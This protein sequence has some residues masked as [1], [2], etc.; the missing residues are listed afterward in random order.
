MWMWTW[1]VDTHVNVNMES[2]QLTI[3]TVHIHIQDA[4]HIK[5]RLNQDFWRCV[6]AGARADNH[7]TTSKTST[8]SHTTTCIHARLV[9]PPPHPHSALPPLTGLLRRSA[10]WVVTHVTHICD[11]HTSVSNS[12]FTTLNFSNFQ[13]LCLQVSTFH[14]S[15]FQ[16]LCLQVS[17][18]QTFKLCV[19]RS[20]LLKLSN[21]VS[22][23][24]NFSRWHC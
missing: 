6:Q 8:S 22:T 7:R 14:V 20:Q 21:S 12:L 9:P 24:L 18:S 5:V 11:T 3:S 17:T 1:K 10:C 15:N 2:R 13:T 23:G 19:Y 4:E 16:T